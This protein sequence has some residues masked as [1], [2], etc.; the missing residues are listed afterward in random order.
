MRSSI[1]LGRFAG[2]RPNHH[3]FGDIDLLVLDKRG[4][5]MGRYSFW[6]AMVEVGA[7][8]GQWTVTARTQLP[9]HVEARLLWEQWR[10]SLPAEKGRWATIP[11]GLREG[12]VEAATLLHGEARNVAA[13]VD[14]I[15]AATLEGADVVDVAS[16][17]CAIGETYRGPGGYFGNYFTS[18]AECLHDHI[19]TRHVRLR[20]ENMPVA[21][22]SLARIVDTVDGPMSQLDLIVKTLSLGNVE[23]LRA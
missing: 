5:A 4:R 9:P 14:A 19:G 3:A 8:A 10:E 21:E 12:W 2:V 7:T 1:D 18:L 16:F 23:V 6:D 15:S 22:H 20:W 17:F 13:S 11:A